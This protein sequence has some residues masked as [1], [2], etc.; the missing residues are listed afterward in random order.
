MTSKELRKIF[1]DF[2]KKRGH[3]VVPS[4]SLLPDDPSVLLTTAG[5]QQFKPY[6][7]GEADPV[8]DFKSKRTASIQKSFRTSDIDEVGD[9]SHLTFFEMLGNFSFGYKPGEP[10]SPN[11]GYF[12]KEAIKYAYDFITKELNLPISYV[13]IFSAKE[14]SFIIPTDEESRE[15]WKALGVSDVREEGM[16]DVFWGPTGNGGPCGPTTEIYCRNASGKDVEI[17]NI[18]FNEY[19]FPGSREELLSGVSGKKLEPLKT[20]GVDTGMGFERL[21]MIVQNVPT[22]FD[23]DLFALTIKALPAELTDRVKRILADH[24]RGSIFLLAEGVLPSNKEAGY[25]LRR[26]VRRSLVYENMHKIDPYI[27]NFVINLIIDEY[28]EVYPELIRSKDAIEAE[29]TKER[30]KFSKT[31]KKGVSELNKLKEK[32]NITASDAFYLY[33]T[34]G[35]PYEI[36]KEIAQEK[37]I[38][39]EYGDFEKEFKRHQEVSRKGQEKKFGGHGL[40]LDTGELKA[41]TEDEVK[42]V[43][44]LH[45][46]THLL[47]SALR[48]VLGGEVKQ[49]GSD[50]TPERMRFDFSFSRK[51]TPEELEKVEREINN[52]ISQ[53]FS[54]IM[55]EMVYEDAIKKG[56]FAFFKEKYPSRVFVYSIKDNKGGF[57]SQE[58]CGGPHVKK[59]SEIG[60]FKII[61][62][63]SVGAGTRRIRAVIE[64]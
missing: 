20:P 13:T 28:S 38:S 51:M 6:Y 4:S 46:A 39:L 53:D 31:L 24:L 14:R 35:L 17:W 1:L 22:I 62:E 63:E 54:V 21:A 49:M 15:I 33:E 37:A 23:T 12:K 58:L 26:L 27:F 11:G 9:E 55:E 10:V 61:K 32:G 5:V 30:D 64:L 18:V 40:I 7:T 50:I 57:Y 2:F 29:F 8:K 48:S 43:T 36:I 41:A 60:K 47:Q 19:F 45:T 25:I 44:R 42:K 59:T 34:F 56:A 3:A 52:V 16:D